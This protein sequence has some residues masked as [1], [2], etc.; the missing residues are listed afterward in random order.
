MTFHE[1]VIESIFRWQTC[2]YITEAELTV[3]TGRLNV[4]FSIDHDYD[5]EFKER[6][7]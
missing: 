5:L 7:T 6:K 3:R 4:Q 1:N 2:R